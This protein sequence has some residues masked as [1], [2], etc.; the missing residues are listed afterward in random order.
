MWN[1]AIASSYGKFNPRSGNKRKQKV[2][3]NL[4]P[5]NCQGI[6]YKDVSVLLASSG[7]RSRSNYTGLAITPK[8]RATY[9]TIY[10]Q[11]LIPKAKKMKHSHNKRHAKGANRQYVNKH[12]RKLQMKNNNHDNFRHRKKKKTKRF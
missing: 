7:S 9:N 6:L 3:G 10:L 12:S 2:G 11:I 5:K 1:R 8:R 4:A